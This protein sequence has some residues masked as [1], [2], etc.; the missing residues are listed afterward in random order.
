MELLHNHAGDIFSYGDCIT[1]CEAAVQ[2]K[3][4]FVMYYT[5]MEYGKRIPMIEGTISGVVLSGF[6]PMTTYSNS[7]CILSLA[8]AAQI[9]QHVD[10]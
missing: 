9:N 10:I 7:L 2:V 1:I 8:Y 3:F 4:K 5:E 6:G